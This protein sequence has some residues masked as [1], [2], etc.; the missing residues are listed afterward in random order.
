MKKVFFLTVLSALILVGAG[1]GSGTE[2]AK[3]KYECSYNAYDCGDFSTHAKAQ[4]VF[5]YCGGVNSDVHRLDGDK[6]G[7]ACETLP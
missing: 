1:C 5:M 4:E 3:K 6:D 7:S 2:T